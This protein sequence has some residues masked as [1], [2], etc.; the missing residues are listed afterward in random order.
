[1]NRLFEIPFNHD[2]N[3]LNFLIKNKMILNK[4]IKHI[5]IAPFIEDYKSTRHNEALKPNSR[6]MYEDQINQLKQ[7]GYEISILFNMPGIPSDEMIDYYSNKIGATSFIIHNDDVA[8]KI[9]SLGLVTIASITKRMQLEDLKTKDLSMYDYIVLDYTFNASYNRIEQLPKKYKYVLM[10]N[11]YCD[12]TCNFFDHWTEN[13]RYVC[14][15]DINGYKNTT[16]IH[17]SDL[18]KFD[19][20]IAFYK[21]Q[22]REYPTRT[23]QRDIMAYIFQRENYSETNI[24]NTDPEYYFRYK[25]K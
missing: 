5:F 8:K 17:P 10:V 18:D 6:D 14:P 3:F 24:N 15:K 13:P 25:G 16:Y 21:I 20:H 19:K 4:Y 1:M 23:I 12:F 7:A 11:T 22:G 9:K 2:P